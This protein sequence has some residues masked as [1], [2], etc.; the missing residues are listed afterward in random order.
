M[1]GRGPG[2]PGARWEFARGTGIGQD[3]LARDHG[4]MITIGGVGTGSPVVPGSHHWLELDG[5]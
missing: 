5:K 4:Q 2:A 3:I 1:S